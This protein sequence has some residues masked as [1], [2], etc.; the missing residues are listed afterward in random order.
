RP[1]GERK[2]FDT[3]KQL[4]WSKLKV[5]L[6]LAVALVILVVAVF[7]AAN[8]QDLFTKKAELRIQFTDAMGL[9]KG[10][11]VW[12]LGIEEGAVKSIKLSSTYGV[13]VII[14]VN[15]RALQFVNKESH[16]TIMTMGL[17]GDKY[18]E[19]S[20][21]PPQGESIRPGEMI[22]GSAETGMRS[23]MET[24][25]V[26]IDKMGQFIERVD[27]L[28]T[29]IEQGQGTIAKF[30]NDPTLYNNLTEASQHLSEMV[31][32]MRNA[33]GTMKLLFEDPSLY[34][35]ALSTASSLEAFS[36]RLNESSGTLKRLIED[37]ELYERL[38]KASLQ[39]SSLLEGIER[40]KGIAGALIR[41]EALAKDLRD[42]VVEF[43]KL[44]V[45]IEALTKDIKEHPR[46][47]L[48]FSLF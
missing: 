18:I 19:L 13:V 5:G 40:G 46:R 27:N 11:P 9:R 6:V 15:K 44:S 28:V 33:Q 1:I 17:L 30:L 20:A 24:V 2:M 14:T 7:F 35:K 10:A 41:D 31:Q 16:A 23:V 3:K 39:L 34:N 8:I 45:E 36:K 21:G 38:D 29:K 48:K 4:Q 12:I 32:E 22:K 37:P 47:Y 42:V 25:G 43:R 26:A